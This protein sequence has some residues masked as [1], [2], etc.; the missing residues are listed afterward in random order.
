[1][2]CAVWPGKI[3]SD[4]TRTREFLRTEMRGGGGRTRIIR[5]THFLERDVNFEIS[6]TWISLR[7]FSHLCSCHSCVTP[8]R[9]IHAT[10]AR[11]ICVMPYCFSGRLSPTAGTVHS[12]RT[13]VMNDASENDASLL[14]GNITD[15]TLI[16]LCA[17]MRDVEVTY[18]LRNIGARVIRSASER[19]VVTAPPTTG[20]VTVLPPKTA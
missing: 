8:C 14:P 9:E 2:I 15:R 19:T 4:V 11:A 5:R 3:I 13:R 17:A 6:S 16:E 1:M 10:M 18:S 12:L 20:L 7:C